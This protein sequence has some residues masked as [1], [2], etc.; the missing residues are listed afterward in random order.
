MGTAQMKPSICSIAWRDEPIEVVLPIAAQ[1]GYLGVEVWQPHVQR[2]LESHGSLEMLGALLARQQL[3]VPMVSGYYDLA[4]QPQES[5][6]ALATHA[7]QAVALGA[8]L[9]RMFTGGESS[10]EATLSVWSQV[11]AA[12]QQ[13]CDQLAPMGL[14]I[15][16]E[17]HEGNLHDATPSTLRL[18]ERVDRP[19]LCIN[20]DIFNLYAIG[21]DP[22]EA[23]LRLRPHVRM[24]HLKNAVR[25]GQS[26]RLGIPLTEGEMPYRPFLDAVG[27]SDY[28]RFAS[29]EWFGPEPAQAAVGE[30]SY[31][32]QELGGR[33]AQRPA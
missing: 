5:L 25:Q 24:I 22:C 23:W 33:L 29:V 7:Q 20:L 18:L 15:A 13:A 9:L 12:L 19:N 10:R 3:A 21:E 6:D 27:G 14:A 30:I 2:H 4:L 32:R 8:P 11:V 31:L 16:L 28:D 26:R 17:T 1:A